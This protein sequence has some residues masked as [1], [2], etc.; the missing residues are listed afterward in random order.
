MKRFLQNSRSGRDQDDEVQ[1]YASFPGT[2]F[3]VDLSQIVVEGKREEFE[4]REWLEDKL[5]QR[6]PVGWDMEWEPDRNG[7]DNPVALMQFADEHICLLLRTYIAERAA[8]VNWLP[9]VVHRFATQV[10]WYR[11]ESEPKVEDARKWRKIGK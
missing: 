6:Q 7:T 8:A 10:A 5:A 11:L 2:V 9:T 3:V 4:G 1:E